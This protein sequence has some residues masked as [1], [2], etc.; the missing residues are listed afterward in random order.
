[1]NKISLWE[2]LKNTEQTNMRDWLNATKLISYGVVLEV[3]D[4][5]TVKVAEVVQTSASDGRYVITLLNPS[6]ALFELYTSPQPGDLVLM[7]FLQRYD[8]AMF[9]LHANL[10]DYILNRPD[11]SGY[12]NWSGVGILLSPPKGN[13]ALKL[14]QTGT[15]AEPSLNITTKSKLTAFFDSL[16]QETFTHQVRRHYAQSAALFEMYNAPVTR[17]HGYMYLPTDGSL[18]ESPCPVTEEYSPNA[19]VSKLYQAEQTIVI[20]KDGDDDVD[21]P[22]S[23]TAGAKADITLKSGS[24]ITLRFDG[25]ASVE[26]GDDGYTIQTSGPVDVSGTD[27]SLSASGS[28]SIKSG[29]GKT[30]DIGNSA[31]TIGAMINDLLTALSSLNTAGSATAQTV[32]PAWVT[33]NI[34]PL[35]TKWAQ[36]FKV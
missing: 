8:S 24:G 30:V 35:Q 20:G 23:I 18:I 27:V 12:T 25:P 33:A 2:L 14:W 11:A 29:A 5:Q 4:P 17:R 10:K 32:N 31:G 15:P 36:V 13:S 34:V 26:A 21:A 19:P 28:V 22:V 6:S 1:M 3:I 7:L 9:D 16:V